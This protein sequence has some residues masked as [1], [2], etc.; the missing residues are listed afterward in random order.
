MTQIAIRSV[1]I[2]AAEI[3]SIENQAKHIV[4]NSAIEVGRRLVEAKE[5]LPHGEWG[6]WL[7]ESV[8]YSQSKANSL[9]QVYREYGENSQALGNLGYTQAVALL[10][11][12]GED[13]EAF[14]AEN[15]IETMSTRELQQAVK[16]RIELERQLKESQEKERIAL[17]AHEREVTKRKEQELKYTNW[18]QKAAAEKVKQEAEVERLAALLADANNDEDPAQLQ[19]SLE[20][21]QRRIKELEK[22]LKEKPI[23]IPVKEIVEVVPEETKQELETLRKRE[24]ETSKQLA[25]LKANL[26]KN[27][28]TAAIKVKVCFETLIGNFKELMTAV[29][30]LKNEEQRKAIKERIAGLIE[31]ARDAV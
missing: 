27:N 2:L 19:E 6:K 11:L 29:G 26:E 20:K 22:Q 16:D 15:D 31:Q 28:N 1:D 30:E 18:A 3:I 24:E 23:D 9:M 25:E 5:Q 14:V 12:P 10:A 17:E 7:S 13:R 8:D 4:L 21:S